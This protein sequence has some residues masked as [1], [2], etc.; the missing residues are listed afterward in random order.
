MAHGTTWPNGPGTV[1]RWQRRHENLCKAN[2][3]LHPE[4]I[5]VQ[6]FLWDQAI[7]AKP[8]QQPNPRYETPIKVKRKQ[9]KKEETDP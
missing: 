1:S 4:I 6:Y 9:G 8:D 3:N 5:R 7:D 2:R